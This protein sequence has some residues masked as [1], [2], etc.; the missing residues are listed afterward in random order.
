MEALKG[1][2]DLHVLACPEDCVSAF[3]GLAQRAGYELV[4]GAKEDVLNRYCTAIRRFGIGRVVRATGDN[5][6]AFADAAGA[7]NR[8]GETLGADYAGYAALP[9]GAGVESVSAAALLRAE[10]EAAAPAERE[11]VCPYL[12][13][14][15]DQFL[16]HRPL[17]PRIWQDPSL[18][19]TVDTAEDYDRAR[20]LYRSLE[21]EE[22]ARRRQG[23][24]IIEAYRRLFFS[25]GIAGGGEAVR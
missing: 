8:E 9:C 14:R 18:R 25:G 10:R 17:A 23:K 3:K 20:A 5:P 12:Y 21:R 11:H 2:W 22:G 13:R 6:F 7:I 15:P 24:T 16:L 19:F 1:T 4:P